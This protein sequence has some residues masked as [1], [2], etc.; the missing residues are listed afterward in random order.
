MKSLF[1]LPS[2]L[3]LFHVHKPRLGVP[4]PLRRL[5]P[6]IVTDSPCI[7]SVTKPHQSEIHW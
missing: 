7:K 1:I 5:Q 3:R 4:V 2:M 6:Q